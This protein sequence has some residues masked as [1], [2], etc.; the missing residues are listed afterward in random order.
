VVLGT[1]ADRQTA[2]VLADEWAPGWTASVDGIPA[3]VRPTLLTLRGVEL[4][5]G[6]H[7]VRFEYRTPRLL[8]GLVA[9]CSGL[10][11]ALVLL[12]LDRLRR[13]KLVSG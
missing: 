4:P 13:P 12:G 3:P 11:L 6:E 10:L 2:L 8:P 1:R 7:T 9:S 5:P